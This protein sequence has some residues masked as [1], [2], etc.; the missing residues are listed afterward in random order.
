MLPWSIRM[1]LDSL[2]WNRPKHLCNVPLAGEKVTE[3]GL[4]DLG[5]IQGLDSLHLI[6]TE[7]TGAGV[8]ELT[9][10]PRLWE[11]RL[12]CSPGTDQAVKKS[13]GLQNLQSLHL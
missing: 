11:L 2:N 13:V 5:C 12:D 9:A 6:A 4:K 3:A 8:E 10:L 1:H 7:V